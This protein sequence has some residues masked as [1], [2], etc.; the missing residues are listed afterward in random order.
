M[1]KQV[2]NLFISLIIGLTT[3]GQAEEQINK[4]SIAVALPN[5]ENIEVSREIVAKLIQIEL[6][7][8]ETYKVYDEFDMQEAMQ[9][10]K[11]F[12]ENCYGKNCLTELGKQIKAD[13]ILSSS[14]LSF[15]N[16]IVVTMKIMDIHTTEVV[17]TNVMEFVDQKDEIQRMMRM[18]I[19]HMHDI[20]VHPETMSKI[21]HDSKPVVKTD[22]YEIDNT[23]PRIGYSLFSGELH[24]FA[25][26]DSRQGGLDIFPGATLIGYQFEKQ[27]IGTENFSALG[28]ILVTVSGLEQGVAIPS[29][30]LMH[31]IRFGKGGWELAFGP[32][33]GLA[34]KSEG[35]FDTEGVY[36][37][38]GK[39]WTLN[40]FQNSTFYDSEIMNDPAYE[41]DEYLDNRSNTFRLNTRFV[42]A[43]GRT[44]QMG[45][46]NVPVNI[47]YSNMRNSGM[48]GLSVGFNILQ[49][50]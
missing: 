21:A 24:E 43:A 3:Q 30:T 1:K 35:F 6:I 10:N 5:I 19:R 32:G 45:A 25:T 33:F 13:Y 37:N 46:L 17:K 22:V 12:E 29:I 26:R 23:G 18:L 41:V 7:K 15:G 2:L 28:E 14:L 16:R 20:A 38:Q 42:L 8:I 49:N 40:E 48:I 27:Y 4:K 44:F 39:Y 11:K 36:G 47:F 50:K 31:G 34:Q 9:Q